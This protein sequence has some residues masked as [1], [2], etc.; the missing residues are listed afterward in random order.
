MDQGSKLL[1]SDRSR[2]VPSWQTTINEHELT[3]GANFLPLNFKDQHDQ[4]R[5]PD[6]LAFVEDDLISEND[7]LKL[8]IVLKTS[9]NIATWLA[10]G[11]YVKCT[12]AN[13]AEWDRLD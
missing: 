6:Q 10:S 5:G 7:N 2:P 4:Q 13:L 12:Y 11:L 9:K 3:R 1:K 8:S